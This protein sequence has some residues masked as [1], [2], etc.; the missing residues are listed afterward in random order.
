MKYFIGLI[1]LSLTVF[2][3]PAKAA[4]LALDTAGADVAVS[5]GDWVTSKGTGIF[6]PR[7]NVGGGNLLSVLDGSLDQT[8]L[9]T[10]GFGLGLGALKVWSGAN[11]MYS[12]TSVNK[13]VA[14]F[15]GTDASFDNQLY[16]FLLGGDQVFSNKTAKSGEQSE[17]DPPDSEPDGYLD[18][19]FYVTNTGKSVSNG[20][21][22]A[23]ETGSGPNFLVSDV[24]FYNGWEHTFVFLND[25]GAGPDKD[26]DDMVVLLSVDVP[27]PSTT[28]IYALCLLGLAGLKFRRR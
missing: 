9:K 19:A 3:I 2:S 26:A 12:G 15:L 7:T 28:L 11:V 14:T 21:N 16:D 17:I 6:N 1:L 23:D 8:T 24:F 22:S 4:V 20:A 10:A 5:V 18:F 13:Y 27:T 25:T